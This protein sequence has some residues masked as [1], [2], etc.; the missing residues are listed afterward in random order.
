MSKEIT[1]KDKRK[2]YIVHEMLEKNGYDI[3]SMYSIMIACEDCVFRE[4]CLAEAPRVLK[5]EEYINHYI[6]TGET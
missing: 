1:D 4:T 3:G 2:Y 6:E 5:C